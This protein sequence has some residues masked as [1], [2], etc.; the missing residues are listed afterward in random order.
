MSAQCPEALRE[1]QENKGDMSGPRTELCFDGD[2]YNVATWAKHHPGGKIIEFY[3]EKGEDASIAI[4]QFH[5]RS[6]PKVMSILKSLKCR[7]GC[8]TE[9]DDD[10]GKLLP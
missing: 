3:T 9:D 6:M 5:L 10:D 2:Y 1:D 8:D 4:R 7:S